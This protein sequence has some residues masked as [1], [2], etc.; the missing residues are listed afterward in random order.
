MSEQRSHRG[1]SR[2]GA[3]R[4][5]L[6]DA[7]LVP[8]TIR[9]TAAEWARLDAEARRRRLTSGRLI[10]ALVAASAARPPDSAPAL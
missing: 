6:A 9:L 3:G 4:P 10:A 1:G 8:R 5:R 7:A 2:P